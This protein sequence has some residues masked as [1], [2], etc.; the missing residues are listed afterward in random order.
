MAATLLRSATRVYY[1]TEIMASSARTIRSAVRSRGAADSGDDPGGRARRR[2]CAIRRATRPAH[3]LIGHFG[4]YGDHVAG[5]ARADRARAARRLPQARVLLG[6]S[7]RCDVRQSARCRHARPRRCAD[8]S[9]TASPS[10]RRCVPAIFWSAVPRRRHHAADLDDGGAVDRHVPCVTTSGELTEPVWTRTRRVALAP[11]G[12]P[13]RFVDEV[14]AARGRS[15]TRE[16]ALGIARP[17]AVRRAF[18]L[19]RHNRA[20]PASR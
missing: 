3:L 8:A 19:G 5:G 15:G 1:S 9:R 2:R 7:R 16:T 17:A 12:E 10:R 13:A 6:G 20:D 4:T 18:A 11:A 14:A